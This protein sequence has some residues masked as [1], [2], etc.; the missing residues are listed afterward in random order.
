LVT[1][2]DFSFRA[3]TRH[4]ALS[5]VEVRTRQLVTLH[6]AAMFDGSRFAGSIGDRFV[7]REAT[8]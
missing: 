1:L 2:A 5:R 3:V 4:D 6:V 7:D 8:S